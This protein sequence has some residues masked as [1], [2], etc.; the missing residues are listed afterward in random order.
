MRQYTITLYV[1][2]FFIPLLIPFF[3]EGKSEGY[4]E[5]LSSVYG[6][7]IHEY[8][9]I[10]IHE[11]DL[12]GSRLMH[13]WVRFFRNN[14][15][16]IS[17]PAQRTYLGYLPRTTPKGYKNRYDLV[18]DGLYGST[19]WF[20]PYK[21]GFIHPTIDYMMVYKWVPAIDDAPGFLETAFS[22]AK[23]TFLVKSPF[24]KPE[25]WGQLIEGRVGLI[26]TRKSSMLASK[27]GKTAMLKVAESRLEVGLG[28]RT[29]YYYVVSS[30]A[31]TVTP[32]SVITLYTQ[33]RG[34]FL[35][36]YSVRYYAVGPDR[37]TLMQTVSYSHD[38][39]FQIAIGGS[40]TYDNFSLGCAYGLYLLAPGSIYQRNEEE[41]EE[42]VGSEYV[43]HE[44]T[45][46]ALYRFMHY[47]FHFDGSYNSFSD[48]A[49]VALGVSIAF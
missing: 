42:S 40:Y 24:H 35:T 6:A 16:I 45:W 49:E 11:F 19:E 33:V 34:N 22:D 39:D 30:Q 26:P 44:F 20:I 17:H 28:F 4:S 41:I 1:S 3:L 12:S 15:Y 36:P 5:P 10:G 9:E 21:W 48:T 32:S 31:F 43:Y 27:D 18:T 25:K 37:D 2:L 23:L 29:Y 7:P 14:P 8:Y 47:T 38:L 46:Q 13:D